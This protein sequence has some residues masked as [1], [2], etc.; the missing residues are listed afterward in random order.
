MQAHRSIPGWIL[1]FQSATGLVSFWTTIV[2]VIC[3]YCHCQLDI[4]HDR[5]L[6][7]W[8]QYI[9][10]VSICLPRLM[11][12]SKNQH[13]FKMPFNSCP[14]TF[15]A[16]I[17]RKL[18]MWFKPRSCYHTFTSRMAKYCKEITT[19]MLPYLFRFLP[20]CTVSA[21][22]G[23]CPRR[24]RGMVLSGPLSWLYRL[25]SIL[26]RKFSELTHSGVSSSSTITGSQF[27]SLITCSMICQ[28]AESIHHGLSTYRTTKRWLFVFSTKSFQTDTVDSPSCHR[29][30][31]AHWNN[32][33]IIQTA[34]VSL[35][36][37][38]MRR[39]QS[40]SSKWRRFTLTPKVVVL[41]Q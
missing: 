8:T 40:S 26:L 27:R 22:Q 3:F 6:R 15:P 29:K 23:S 39:L 14:Q 36:W 32:S 20:D 19:L 7:L 9:F 13:I 2:S 24:K 38:Y 37:L 21:F 10:G 1:S 35:R 18:F 33:S 34:T 4:I 11:R 25:P 31:T 28:I 5:H 17:H 12:H 41:I 16:R 30:A